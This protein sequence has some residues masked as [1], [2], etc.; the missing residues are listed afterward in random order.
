MEGGGKGRERRGW[1]MMHEF[2]ELVGWLL[3]AV[4]ECRRMEI[5]RMEILRR[6]EGKG[7]DRGCVRERERES[8]SF[9]LASFIG[10]F[11]VPFIARL[12]DYFT[13]CEYI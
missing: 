13:R 1:R 4:L 10:N 9:T 3:E 11:F 12:S 8:G 5:R 6:S 2:H 7:R